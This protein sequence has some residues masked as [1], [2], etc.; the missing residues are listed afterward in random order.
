M[1]SGDLNLEGNKIGK[2]IGFCEIQENTKRTWSKVE[3]KNL[4]PSKMQYTITIT[5][6]PI[7]IMH[8]ITLSLRVENS[9]S[10]MWNTIPT[11]KSR[12]R[13]ESKI[14]ISKCNPFAL[15]GF[16]YMWID[17]LY[18]M[19]SFVWYS[20]SSASFSENFLIC[21]LFNTSFKLFSCYI[22]VSCSS[23]S[24]SLWFYIAGILKKSIELQ[25]ANIC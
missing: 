12:D 10:T 19:S 22:D 23:S 4:I 13:K 11:K 8:S 15:C 24:S 3:S 9:S 5:E 25:F 17:S 1:A 7:P 6:R 20:L 18:E 2:R 14:T 16:K 21:A